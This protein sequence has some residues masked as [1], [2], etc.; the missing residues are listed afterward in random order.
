[1]KFEKLIRIFG[2]FV[3]VNTYGYRNLVS[4][5]QFVCYILFRKYGMKSGDINKGLRN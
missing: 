1:M 2:Y 3:E 4:L 5:G